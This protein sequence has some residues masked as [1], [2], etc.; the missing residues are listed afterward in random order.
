MGENEDSWRLIDEKPT[1]KIYGDDVGFKKAWKG[2]WRS[3]YV[4]ANFV[5]VIYAALILTIDLHLQVWD[6]QMMNKFYIAAAVVHVV[7]AL[8]YIWVWR[9][10]GY[11]FL[12]RIMIPEFLNVIEASLYMVTAMMYSHERYD[13]NVSSTDVQDTIPTVGDDPVLRDVQ[14]IEMVASCVELLA[15]CGWATTWYITYPRIPGRGWTFDDPDIWAN[16]SIIT[17]G[18]LYIIYNVQLQLHPHI[19]GANFLYV[20]ADKIYMGNSL[21]YFICSLRDVGWFW[22]MPTAGSFPNRGHSKS[23]N[24]VV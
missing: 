14:R 17:P 2:T 10:E 6:H 13:N 8:M 12:H 4:C 21:L 22:F 11:P 15:A 1:N 7:N 5:Y 3:P 23:I 16:L 19:Y 9:C 18:I 24:N 20:I